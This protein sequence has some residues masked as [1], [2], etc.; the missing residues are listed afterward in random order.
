MFKRKCHKFGE[1]IKM[2]DGIAYFC[3][4]LSYAEVWDLWKDGHNSAMKEVENV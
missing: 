3:E 1:A 4:C 2:K